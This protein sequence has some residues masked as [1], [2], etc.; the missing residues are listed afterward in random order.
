MAS[1]TAM[2]A[3]KILHVIILRLPVEVTMIYILVYIYFIESVLRS[4]SSGE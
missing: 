3:E 2:N 1:A 4:V